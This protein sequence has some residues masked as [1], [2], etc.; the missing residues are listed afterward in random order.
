MNKGSL[1]ALAFAREMSQDVTALIVSVNDIKSDFIANE[2]LKLNWGIEA[3][4]IESHYRSVVQ[5]IVDHIHQIEHITKK[6]SVIVLGELV[7]PK[8]W[9]H[10]LHNKTASAIEHALIW[11]SPSVGE[12]R[13]VINVPYMVHLPD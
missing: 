13:V 4:Q 6:P 9:Q 3:V 12:S 10:F 1:T 5:P 8:W 11:E 2:I 7:L